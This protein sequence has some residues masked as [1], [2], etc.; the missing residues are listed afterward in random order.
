MKYKLLKP[1]PWI[2]EGTICE[3]HKD[4]TEWVS[5]IEWSTIAWLLD[6]IQWFWLNN[7]FFEPIVE[8]KTYDDLKEGDRIYLINYTGFINERYFEN[9]CRSETFLT[10]QEAEDEH[11]RRELAVRKDRFI[12]N[13]N[14]CYFYPSIEWEV[15]FTHN[16]WC[17]TDYM[18]INAGLVF[19]TRQECQ[20]AIDNHDIVRLFYTIR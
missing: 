5:L 4:D 3:Y 2:K 9:D 7:D 12:P 15:E 6:F 10:R 11:A 20:D 13:K 1:L 19:A 8:K 14:E 16:D 18:M 17:S